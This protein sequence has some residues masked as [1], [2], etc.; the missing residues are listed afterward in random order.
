MKRAT[1]WALAGVTVS[2]TGILG[3]IALRT[4]VRKQVLATLNAPAPEGYDY[5]NTMRKNILLQ[6]GSSILRI[7]SAAAL[8]ESTVPIWSTV[9]PYDAFD[10]I[11]VQGRNSKYWPKGYTSVLP[12]VV[13]SYIFATLKAMS[14]KAKEQEQKK[15]TG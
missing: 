9:H 5:D 13:D 3:W 14:D 6:L 8:A 7:P 15:L 2:A 4:Y 11:L 1:K 10:D 12:K